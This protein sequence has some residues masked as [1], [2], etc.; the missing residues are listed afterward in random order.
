MKPTTRKASVMSMLAFLF[1]WSVGLCSGPTGGLGQPDE[2]E[3]AVEDRKIKVGEP[4]MVEVSLLWDEERTGKKIRE[5]ISSNFLL[6]IRPEA[7]ESSSAE[8]GVAGLGRFRLQEDLRIRYSG[9][10]LVFYDFL[11]ERLVFPDHGRYVIEG[12]AWGRAAEA[13]TIEVGPAGEAE[14]CALELITEPNDYMVLYRGEALFYGVENERRA[15]AKAIETFKKAFQQ[16]EDSVIARWG[17]ARVG[18]ELVNQLR[19]KYPRKMESIKAHVAGKIREPLVEAAHNYLLA[20]LGL[21]ENLELPDEGVNM[22]EEALFSMITA[23]EWKGNYEKC[24]AY[25]DELG[26]KYPEGKYGRRASQLRS[27]IETCLIR[28]ESRYPQGGGQ[29]GPNESAK[30]N[31]GRNKK[32]LVFVIVSCVVAAGLI[33]GI[34]LLARRK[35]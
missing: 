1:L 30:L 17:A 7:T 15:R 16:C 12:Q 29:S 32:G 24:L 27:E 31:T 26:E 28:D 6:I 19:R 2:V 4:L 14:R 21:P 13:V 5:E 8:S 35:P 9:N 3:I 22:R 10:A 11:K 23:A 33:S 20:G 18:I 34:V 25:V